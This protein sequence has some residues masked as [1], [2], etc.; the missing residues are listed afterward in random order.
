MILRRLYDAGRLTRE[1]LNVEYEAE[2]IRLSE[3]PRPS[4][5]SFY[6]TTATRVGRRFA[7]AVV[8]AT[9][10][11]RTSFTEASRLLGFRKMGTFHKLAH[12]LEVEV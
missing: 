7:R 3:I 9:L 12:S 10:E 5:G 6:L 2:L 1:Q 11:G 8:A 4:G